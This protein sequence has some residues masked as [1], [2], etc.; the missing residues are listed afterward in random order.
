MVAEKRREA[1]AHRAPRVAAQDQPD[2]EVVQV[3]IRFSSPDDAEEL[4]RL[5]IIDSKRAPVGSTLVAEVEG[6]IVAALP[7]RRGEPLA[8]P[9]RPTQDIVRLLELR[10]AQLRGQASRGGRSRRFRRWRLAES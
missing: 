2:P 8:D 7:L 3:T 1:E 9:F 6:A 5:A 10:A 4:E